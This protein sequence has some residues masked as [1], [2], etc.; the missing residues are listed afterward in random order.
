MNSSILSN[1]SGGRRW[2]LLAGLLAAGLTSCSTTHQVGETPK[3]FS[4]FLG[5]YSLLQKGGEG[6]ANY[7]YIDKNAPWKTYTKVCILPVELWE[8]DDPQ[9][10]FGEMSP[11]NQQI[12]V[13]MYHT[14]MAQAV[15][16]QFEIV[17]QPGPDTL[18][19]HAAITEA[20]KSHPV[21]NLISSVYPAA[22]VIS[23]GKQMITGTGTGV[24]AVRIEAYFTDGVTGQRVAEVVDARAGTKAWRSKFDGS[25][26]DVKLAFD[27][28]CNRF[29]KRLQLFQQDDFGTTDL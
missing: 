16:K 10:P 18:V 20:R 8:S 7:V 2:K 17:T 12:L 19:V 23:Y 22:L 5:D 1:Q 28:W 29:V 27:W 6:Q 24:G 15:I 9:S 25:W 13:S 14:A 4:G 11:E 3:E 21:L 26:G